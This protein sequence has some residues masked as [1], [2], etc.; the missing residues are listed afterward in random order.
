MDIFPQSHHKNSRCP[1]NIVFLGRNII[2]K[3]CSPKPADQSIVSGQD[4]N[5][6][7]IHLVWL[8]PPLS[9]LVWNRL[10]FAIGRNVVLKIGIVCIATINCSRLKTRKCEINGVIPASSRQGEKQ[11]SCHGCWSRRSS[12][13][14]SDAG[15][16]WAPGEEASV[17]VDCT[18]LGPLLSNGPIA[19]VFPPTQP[20]WSRFCLEPPC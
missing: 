9:L 13:N 8:S 18:S 6:K 14:T 19:I 17:P 7:I 4:S 3:T 1:L 12:P 16:R 2:M 11:D 15:G 20:G 10:C 5:A